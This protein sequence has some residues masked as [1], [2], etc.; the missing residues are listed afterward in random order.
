MK[1]TGTLEAERLGWVFRQSVRDDVGRVSNEFLPRG[2][3]ELVYVTWGGESDKTAAG[4]LGGAPVRGR[5]M[6][7]E[8]RGYG[9]GV[10]RP[11]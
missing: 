5:Q 9:E 6:I 7:L 3:R 8:S 10:T 1:S 11:C 4:E 2:E